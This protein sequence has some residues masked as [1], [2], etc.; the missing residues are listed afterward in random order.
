MRITGH[1]NTLTGREAVEVKVKVNSWD[2]PPIVLFAVDADDYLMSVDAEV[3]VVLGCTHST[4]QLRKSTSL[5]IGCR[6]TS[7]SRRRV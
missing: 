2:Y 6:V 5:E 3:G 4:G 1:G 7:R